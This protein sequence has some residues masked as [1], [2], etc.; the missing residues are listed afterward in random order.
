MPGRTGKRSKA[1]AP[2]ARCGKAIEGAFNRERHGDYHPDCWWA[3]RAE[4]PATKP[5]KS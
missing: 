5:I 2:C 4:R 1:P 3:M